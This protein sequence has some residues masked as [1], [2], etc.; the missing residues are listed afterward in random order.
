M[1]K[2]TA[3]IPKAQIEKILTDR[4][5][6]LVGK[7]DFQQARQTI[8]K[9]AYPDK[10]LKGW[11]EYRDTA[12]KINVK[13]INQFQY[14][15][16]R[17]LGGNQTEFYLEETVKGVSPDDQ[18][19]RWNYHA[20]I[21]DFKDPQNPVLV[22]KPLL[23]APDWIVWQEAPENWVYQSAQKRFCNFQK[24]LKQQGKTHKL[25]ICGEESEAV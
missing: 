13:Y 3:P 19:E 2:I 1:W 14:L 22:E 17:R 23:Q 12:P 20:F 9:A 18:S 24:H 4:L 8:P 11:I 7:A 16:Q 15:G 5:D 25:N 21:Y 10:V 6:L